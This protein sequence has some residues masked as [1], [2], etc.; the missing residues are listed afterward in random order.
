ME[1]KAKAKYIR[2]SPRKVRLVVDVIRGMGITQGMNQLKFI[3]KK[4]SGPVRKLLASAIANAANNFE[5]SE[6]NLYIKEAR[7]DEGP[8]LRRWRPRARGRATPIRKRT[9]HI[10]IV[11]AEIVDSGQKEGKKQELEAPLKMSE[12]KEKKQEDKTKEKKSK[13]A[14]KPEEKTEPKDKK[15]RQPAQ[16]PAQQGSKG[17][18]G[19]MF[20]RK[21]G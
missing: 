19:K 18:S 10:N 14:A 13:Q 12:N 6:D 16:K 7:V 2:I 11:L 5:L 21:A 4:A 3:N 17:V 1:V 8:T 15:T 9:S 20:R